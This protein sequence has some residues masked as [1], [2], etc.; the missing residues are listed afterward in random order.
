MEQI[1]IFVTGSGLGCE[2]LYIVVQ[3]Q[4]FLNTRHTI[5]K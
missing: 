2:A 4:Q 1:Y 3:T 5:V